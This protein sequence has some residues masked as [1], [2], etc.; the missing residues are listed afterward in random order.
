MQNG[1]FIRSIIPYH[2]YH[3]CSFFIFISKRKIYFVA[4]YKFILKII[5]NQSQFKF[6]L[7]NEKARTLDFGWAKESTVVNFPISKNIAGVL[8]S[9]KPGGLR[10][11]HWHANAA[12]WG[13]IISGNVRTTI[14]DPWG[15]YET[16]DFKKGDIWYFPKGHGHSI[17]GLDPD[18]TTFMLVFD[19]G[20]FS[21]FATF[22]LSDWLAQT[23]HDIVSKNLQV[24]A[25]ALKNLPKKEVYI[26]DAPVARETSK[27]ELP[28]LT[29]KYQL[30]H[31]K[32]FRES[33]GGKLWMA[34][35]VEFPISSTMSGGIMILKPG[36]LRELHWHPNA[37]EWVYVISGK[38]R[39]TEF[40]SG[41]ESAIVDLEEGDVGYTP[42]GLGHCLE[43]V[44]DTDCEMIIVFNSGTYEE[45]SLTSWLASNPDSLVSANLNLPEDVVKKFPKESSFIAYKK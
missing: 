25:E 44:G 30:L 33:N 42:M 18:G 29:H 13:Y 12:E 43:N 14:I 1:S 4:H 31:Q 8:M 38:V 3:S 16:N 40:A 35:S 6:S 22:S 5:L 9:L 27:L 10:E 28:P 37:D 41:G 32:P 39:M 11:L 34:S 17:Q 36:A 2:S 24:N 26:V 21:E 23:P 45:I 15:K 20:A 7:S 19:N